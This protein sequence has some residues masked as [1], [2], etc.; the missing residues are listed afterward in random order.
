[1]EDNV[2]APAGAP[3][4][5]PEDEGNVSAQPAAAAPGGESG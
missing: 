5:A 4:E 2:N 3:I 1:M